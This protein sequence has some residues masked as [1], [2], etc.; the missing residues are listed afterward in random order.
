MGLFGK[1]P[2]IS[3]EEASG[4]SPKKLIAEMRKGR[5]VT[6]FS[7]EQAEHLGNGKMKDKPLKDIDKDYRKRGSFDMEGTIKRH[8]DVGGVIAGLFGSN[9][10]QVARPLSE[11]MHPAAYKKLIE[12]EVARRARQRKGQ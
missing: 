12:R 10:R 3:A 6:G 2:P 1:K 4:M 9:G 8:G 11:T 5:T 7:Y